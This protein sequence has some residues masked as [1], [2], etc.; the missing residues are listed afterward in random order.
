MQRLVSRVVHL[1]PTGIL[2]QQWRGCA[3]LGQASVQVQAFGRLG[4]LP[5]VRPLT[6]AEPQRT[7]KCNNGSISIL[8]KAAI[9]KWDNKF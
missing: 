4:D 9:T 1:V 8:V 2:R 3:Y 5:V 7:L 6:A